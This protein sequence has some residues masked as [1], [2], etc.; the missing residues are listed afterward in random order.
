MDSN[1]AG[2]IPAAGLA[3]RLPRLPVSKEIFPLSVTR[4]G[5]SGGP[6]VNTPFDQLL[7]KMSFAK[8]AEIYVVIRR[9]KWDIPNYLNAV[10]M[11]DRNIAYLMMEKPYGSLFSTNQAYPFTA[12]KTIAFGFPDILF[13]ERDAFQTLLNHASG[14]NADVVLGLFP[15]DQPEKVDMVDIDDDG[16]VRRLVIKQREN[17][18]THAWGLAVWKPAFSD[19]IDSFIRHMERQISKNPHKFNLQ[20]IDI[21]VGNAIEMALDEGMVVHGI[22]VSEKP[23][24]DIGTPDDMA[25]AIRLY[26][27]KPTLGKS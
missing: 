26:S 8:I 25:R 13:D 21:H 14:S 12:G 17:H 11:S 2:I 27:E 5:H 4:G 1:I 3:K 19:F 9:G 16:K 10:P 24:L 15:S 23:F 18:L 20:E 7:D 6:Q 22:K